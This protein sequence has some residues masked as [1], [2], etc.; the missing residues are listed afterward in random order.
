VTRH[1]PDHEPGFIGVSPRSQQALEQY[2]A[3]A[4]QHLRESKAFVL[5]TLDPD[6]GAT[7]SA[8]GL[9][10]EE[11]MIA[12]LFLAATR[13]QRDLNVALRSATQEPPV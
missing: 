5:M 9:V 12:L 11:D 2:H 4:V 1:M 6:G 10:E 7:W 8:G 3:A 13:A